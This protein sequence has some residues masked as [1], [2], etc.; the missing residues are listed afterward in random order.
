M[1]TVLRYIKFWIDRKDPLAQKSIPTGL[2]KQSFI[3]EPLNIPE[4]QSLP[5]CILS[6]TR[7][8]LKPKILVD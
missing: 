7:M 5:P 8:P 3:E 6:Q 2:R 4:R 1:V